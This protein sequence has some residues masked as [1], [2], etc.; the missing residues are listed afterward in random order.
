MENVQ[1]LWIPRM[2][3][4]SFDAGTEKLATKGLVN[5]LTVLERQLEG[6]KWLVGKEVSLADIS[7]ASALVWGF[8]KFI[9][10]EM[11]GEFPA[12]VS[13]YERVLETEGVRQAFGEKDF[14]EKRRAWN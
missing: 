8:S 11:R 5:A 14:I 2:G 1:N 4:R 12:V 13:W 7:V 6:A 3:L 9:D 10:A